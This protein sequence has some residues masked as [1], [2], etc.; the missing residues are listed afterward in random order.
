MSVRVRLGVESLGTVDAILC[1][2]RVGLLTNAAATDSTLVPSVDRVAAR[3]GVRLLFG[4]EHG[5]RG[6]L[7]AGEAVE[8]GVDEA[9][10]VPVRSLYGEQRAPSPEDLAG[11]DAL[12][13]DL[14]DVGSRY[15][16][17][18]STLAHTM[19]ACADAGVPV[20]VLD[21]P[22]PLGGAVVEGGVPRPE[23][24]SFVGVHPVPVRHGLTIA[25]YARLVNELQPACDLHWAPLAGW[26]RSWHHRE[27]G[28]P[29]VMPSPNIPTAET[30][31]A[32]V[33]TC[34]FE[35]T[36]VSEGRGTAKPF[37]LFGAPW[38]V[39]KRVLAAVDRRRLTGGAL[40]DTV[41]R[42]FASKYAH[43]VCRGFE[44]HVVEPDR[45]SPYA[46]GVAVLDAIRRTH[47]AFAFREPS[48]PGDRFFIDLLAG[49]DELRRGDPPADV[50]LERCAIESEAFLTWRSP[51]LLY[52]E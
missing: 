28:L 15:Y 8:S 38:L 46:A 2:R 24:A 26:R 29:W 39:P 42:P 47:D 33:G 27:L 35:G 19:R 16:T 50:Y 1:G 9:T 12:V 30:A 37:L 44:L 51:C 13:V 31:L 23:F 40:R 7:D 49:S 52:R 45:F 25:E 11:I 21:R 4:P 20:V 5:V 18:L 14:P 22:N 6:D 3:Y 34:L 41:F 48:P 10:G 43:E 17:Y 32:Y 36:N